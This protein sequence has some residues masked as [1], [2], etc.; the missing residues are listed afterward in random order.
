M[1]F[2]RCIYECVCVCVCVWVSYFLNDQFLF[3]RCSLHSSL[4]LCMSLS[5]SVCL[6]SI[7]FVRC[8]LFNVRTS[9]FI[10]LN[11]PNLMVLLELFTFRLH[12]VFSVRWWM[13]ITER[14]QINCRLS[15]SSIFTTRCLVFA[16]SVFLDRR[17]NLMWS[18]W[19][20][21]FFLIRSRRSMNL[22]FDLF[23]LF[24]W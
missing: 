1:R 22:T 7:E 10:F 23:L 3:H 15:F 17:E 5:L 24:V 9:I 2:I 11:V 18:I 6:P 14:E 20:L 8:S 19:W 16:F 21:I 4:F 13:K 12:L